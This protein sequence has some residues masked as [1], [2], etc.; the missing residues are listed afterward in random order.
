MCESE[1][2]GACKS[3][4]LTEL[5]CFHYIIFVFAWWLYG[6]RYRD[7]RS[8]AID[9]RVVLGTV[10]LDAIVIARLQLPVFEVHC[11]PSNVWIWSLRSLYI[12]RLGRVLECFHYIIFIFVWWL[13]GCRSCDVRSSIDFR[14]VV[15]TV[16]LGAIVIARLQLT[17]FEVHCVPSNE[18]IWSLRSL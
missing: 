3:H 1:V 2:C 12:T 15:W 16:A 18:W 9:V 13:Y 14:V 8:S 5:E 10:A 4:V 17:V 7:V 6:C 11:V